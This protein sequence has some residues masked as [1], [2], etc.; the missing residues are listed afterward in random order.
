MRVDGRLLSRL[1]ADGH[2][3][4]EFIA[5][6]HVPRVEIVVEENIWGERGVADL[7]ARTKNRARHRA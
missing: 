3:F 2:D 5:V 6:N 1:P 4:E 7:D